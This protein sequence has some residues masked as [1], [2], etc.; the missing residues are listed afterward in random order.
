MTDVSRLLLAQEMLQRLEEGFCT[1]NCICVTLVAIVL[2]AVIFG[3]AL[4]T[5][6]LT[7]AIN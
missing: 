6:H 7:T 1:L 4:V 3:A 2:T 5:L